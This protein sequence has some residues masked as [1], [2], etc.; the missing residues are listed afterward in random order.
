MAA[1]GARA[2]VSPPLPFER[3]RVAR[4]VQ[5]VPDPSRRALARGAAV[6]RARPSEHGLVARAEQWAWSSLAVW[7]RRQRPSWLEASPHRA[8]AGLG[9]TGQRG[10]VGVGPGAGAA[11]SAK[12]TARGMGRS[13]GAWRQRL[14]WGWNRRCDRGDGPARNGSV[15][16]RRPRHLCRG[17]RKGDWLQVFEVPVPFLSTGPRKR[18]GNGYRHRAG[19]GLAWCGTWDARPVASPSF[20]QPRGLSPAENGGRRPK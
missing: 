2:A 9:R 14:S 10:A 16:R 19:R 8:A 5:G 3:S 15:A 4:T 1:H 6:R 13:R 7:K 18:E 12:R 20:L 11:P 17:V